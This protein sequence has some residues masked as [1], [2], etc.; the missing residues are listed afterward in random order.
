MAIPLFILSEGVCTGVGV[1]STI[2]T[3][4]MGT[5]RTVSSIYNHQNPDVNRIMRDLDINHKL[6]MIHSVLNR[7][8]LEQKKVAKVKLNDLEKTQ[9]FEIIETADVNDPISLCLDHLY[10]SMQKIHADLAIIND[11]IKQHNQ[12]WFANWRTLNIK[13]NLDELRE[14]VKNMSDRFD[15]FLKITAFFTN[16]KS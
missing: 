4:A 5:C 2:G 6:Q 9:I 1:I 11:K 14:D 7:F 3:L 10:L 13:S 12:R 15:V 8:S 16:R